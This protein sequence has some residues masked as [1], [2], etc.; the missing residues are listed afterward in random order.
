MA[1]SILDHH[2]N[3]SAVE[4]FC[5][6]GSPCTFTHEKFRKRLK[7]L[8]TKFYTRNGKPIDEVI[9]IP[10]FTQF[11]KTQLTSIWE[12]AMSI[13]KEW[14]K[15]SSINCGLIVRNYNI[16]SHLRFSK[17]KIDINE[18]FGQCNE[19]LLVFNPAQKVVLTIYFVENAETLEEEVCNCIDEVNLLGLLLRDESK[20]SGIVVTGVVAC[21]EENSYNSCN[22]CNNFIVP[23]SIFTS[24]ERFISFWDSCITQEIDKSIK[25][26]IR[27]DEL[28]TFEAVATEMVG[29]LAHMQYPTADKTKLPTPRNSPEENISET[30][31]L[32]NRY[33]MEVVYS[34][35]N[36]IFLTGSYGTCKSIIIEKKI[37]N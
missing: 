3:H 16:K 37:E 27:N 14:C 26:P 22:D 9:T 6:A 29:F 32:L 24:L 10:I 33:Q 8:F 19:R 30:E 11:D 5:G 20:E 21:P 36:R 34:R 15:N 31:L 35:Q 18:K 7:D 1:K 2:F 4:L 13:L 23:Y 17:I 25:D 12:K 28:K